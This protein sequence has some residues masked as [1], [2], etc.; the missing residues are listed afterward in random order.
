[1]NRRHTSSS[2][3]T[4]IRE[5]AARA[6][7]SIKTVS[8][9]INKEPGLR[10]ET[11]A[12]VEAAIA[13]LHYQPNMAARVLAGS[14]SFRLA[15]LYDHTQ[16][17]INFN[18]VINLQSGVLDCART[19]GYDL[20]IHPCDFASRTLGRE[21]EEMARHTKL[22]GLILIPPLS[23]RRALLAQLVNAGLLLCTI[24]SVHKP[25]SV[26]NV[27]CD[28]ESASYAITRHLIDLGHRRIA[29]I[30]GHPDHGASARR[31][32]GFMRAMQEAGLGVPERYVQQGWFDFESGKHAGSVLLD[33]NRRPSAIFAANDEMAAGAVHAALRQGL[34]VPE[35]LSVTGFDDS[36]TALLSWPTLTTV[37]QPTRAM[38]RL[39]AQL[40]VEA[41]RTPREGARPQLHT[42]DHE[43]VIRE[44]TARPCA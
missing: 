40:L 31:L 17:H 21:I 30:K 42:L 28:D 35:Q 23:D 14:H 44:S 18:Y 36:M 1:M 4:T 32:S 33:L 20:L 29:I 22:S 9:V 24:S 39:A 37:R 8:R 38:A 34:T 10:P 2:S 3:R 19:E 13:D 6:E 27:V 25:V 11:R 7:V 5:V 26:A 12:R 15:L 43:I 41:R 16:D